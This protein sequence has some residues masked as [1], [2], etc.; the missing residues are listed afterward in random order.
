[1][2]MMNERQMVLE[3]QLL[4]ME[5]K[6]VFTLIRSLRPNDFFYVIKWLSYVQIHAKNNGILK[7]RRILRVRPHRA[8]FVSVSANTVQR[9]L[10]ISNL[11]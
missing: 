4:W 2:N 5:L 3:K 6:P 8:F 1:M 9:T 11:R 7:A 10:Y